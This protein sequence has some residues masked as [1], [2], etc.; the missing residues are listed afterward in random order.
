MIS[1]AFFLP[2]VAEGP[3]LGGIS[4]WSRQHAARPRTGEQRPS[5]ALFKRPPHFCDCGLECL[6]RRLG[7]LWNECSPRDL[8]YGTSPR[9][10]YLGCRNRCDRL[11]N[12]FRYRGWNK[13]QTRGRRA[14]PQYYRYRDGIGQRDNLLFHSDV[15]RYIGEWYLER[16]LQD[17]TLTDLAR[18]FRLRTSCLCLAVRYDGGTWHD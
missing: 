1:T 13:S 11:S 6:W 18:N 15:L 10:P 9:S 8:H 7:Q 2:T 16:S 5:P 14:G 17:Y 12:L 3:K 4:A